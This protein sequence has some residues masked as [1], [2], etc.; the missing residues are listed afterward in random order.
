MKED[1]I[2]VTGNVNKLNETKTILSNYH[3]IYSLNEVIVD[4]NIH[5]V[6]FDQLIP[7]ETGNSYEENAVSKVMA[8][9]SKSETLF[10]NER[11]C[12][13]IIMADDCGIEIDHFNGKPGLNSNRI[14]FGM[15]SSDEINKS[16]VNMM[17]GIIE[18]ESRT[19][20]YVCAVATYFP[21]SGKVITT[22]ATLEGIIAKK[23]A[24]GY[25]V[26][27]YG[28]DPIFF[29]PKYA[30]T[31]AELDA[32]I[33]YKISHRC[34]ALREASRCIKIENLTKILDIKNNEEEL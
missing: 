27:G 9:A 4:D 25:G 31:T 13:A 8:I 32:N 26:A 34:K 2:F 30:K 5:N 3:T 19:C 23:V 6:P 20:R 14:K 16:I 12:R 10:K 11:L 24:F 18:D 29:I 15:F 1:V 33:I 21:D 17:D 22:R 28:Y 7:E